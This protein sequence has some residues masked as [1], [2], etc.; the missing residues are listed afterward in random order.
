MGIGAVVRRA[1]G[2]LEPALAD[3]YRQLFFDIGD[4]A[5]RLASLGH[6]HE[7]RDVV[8]IGCGEGALLSRLNGRLPETRFI[9]IDTSPALGRLFDG[10][11][12]SNVSFKR[13]TADHLARQAPQSADLVVICDVLHH[14]ASDDLD[15]VVASAAS[16]V[17]PG[18]VVVV[19]EWIRLPGPAYWVGWLSDRLLTGDRVMY[20]SREGWLAKVAQAAPAMCLEREWRL[21]PWASNHALVFRAPR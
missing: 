20:R 14:V 13:T 19:K 5:E 17:K 2:P 12:R 16:L 3:G 18:G 11:F 7:L 21:A 8:E 1:A 10:P 9:G 15:S 6:A 4:F